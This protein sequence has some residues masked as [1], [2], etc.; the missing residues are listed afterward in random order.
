MLH[1]ADNKIKKHFLF[2]H[3]PKCAGTS[4]EKMF[5]RVYDDNAYIEHRVNLNEI[6]HPKHLTIKSYYDHFNNNLLDNS[7]KFTIVRN[8]FD[9]LVSHYNY[10]IKSERVFMN[11]SN[12]YNVKKNI[13]FSDFINALYNRQR[14]NNST[15]VTSLTKYVNYND[16]KLDFIGKFENLTADMNH[17]CN[18]LGIQNNLPH[19]NKNDHKNY[20]EYYDEN[21]KK[22]VYDMFG[23]DMVRFKYDF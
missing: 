19:I 13:K 6:E 23:N 1:I 17:I 18:V 20:R 22:M 10:N 5:N 4:I 11:G 14:D 7:F 15:N 12:D 8:P 3:I 2:I 21:T 16:F 9:L